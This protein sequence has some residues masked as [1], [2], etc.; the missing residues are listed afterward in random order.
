METRQILQI[1]P[2]SGW[3]AEY[4]PDEPGTDKPYYVPLAGWALVK[5]GDDTE[6]HGMDAHDFVDFCDTASNFT[7]YTHEIQ[8]T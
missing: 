1:I 6:I 8:I 7:R 5:V 4:K 2:A 3:F